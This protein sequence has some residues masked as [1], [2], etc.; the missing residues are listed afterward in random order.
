MLVQESVL[1]PHNVMS[2]VRVTATIEQLQ[3]ADLH[4][5]LVVVGWLVLD[6]LQQGT[7]Q[8]TLGTE[9]TTRRGKVC[10]QNAAVQCN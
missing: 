10:A 9:S 6:H 3:D 4:S 1:Q 7:T 8:T 2:I 5:S